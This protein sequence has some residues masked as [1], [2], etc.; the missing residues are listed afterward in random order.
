MRRRFAGILALLLLPL[1][2]LPQVLSA[3]TRQD[4][5]RILQDL[6]LRCESGVNFEAYS[7]A[8]D[9]TQARLGEF[10]D[11]KESS[12]NPE[13]SEKIERA[14]IAYQSAFIIWKGK[15]EY[16]QD[17]ISSDHPTIRKMLA[18]Y[19]DAASLFS[20]SGQASPSTLVSFFWDKADT[21]ISEA[22]KMISGRRK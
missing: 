17:S 15:I 21:R 22:K 11:S 3:Q 4:A 14:L 2:F 13:F 9:E 20:P 16:K 18:I 1:F 7:S 12:R 10:F 19:P 6:Q 5:L 8:L